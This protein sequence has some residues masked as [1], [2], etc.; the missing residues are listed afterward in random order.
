MSDTKPN[1]SLHSFEFLVAEAEA[2]VVVDEPD[3]LHECIY[4]HRAEELEAAR[5]EFGGDSVRKLRARGGGPFVGLR[6]VGI[7]QRLA[8]RERPE[9]LRERAAFAAKRDE[10]LRVVD[11]GVDLA[12]RADHTRH[13]KDARDV[14]FAVAG[15]LLEV[16]PLERDAERRTLLDDRVPAKSALQHLVHQVLEEPA[17]VPARH[18]PLLVVVCAIKVVQFEIWAAYLFHCFVLAAKTAKEVL[19]HDCIVSPPCHTS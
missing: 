5:L 16:E 6:V 13:G 14:A 4:R 17:V 10:A 2:G 3:G 18:P 1:S 15:D 9:P 7:E 12:A 11:D 19:F 8:V